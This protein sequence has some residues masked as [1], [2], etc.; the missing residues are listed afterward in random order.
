M[1]VTGTLQIVDEFN[2]PIAEAQ[3]WSF[4]SAKDSALLKKT[5]YIEDEYYSDS[6]TYSFY[7]GYTRWRNPQ[8][9]SGKC[10]LI[11]APG[12]ADIHVG[13]L[14]FNN[15]SYLPSKL[16]LK[17]YRKVAQWRGENLVTA[18]LYKTGS[19]TVTDSLMMDKS[20]YIEIL[21]EV[22]ELRPLN[23]PI[24]VFPNPANDQVEIALNQQNLSSA[25][26][27]MVDMSGA[28][29]LEADITSSSMAVNISHLKGGV[30]T[31]LFYDTGNRLIHSQ[32]LV[33]LASDY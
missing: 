18:S 5:A 13:S 20:C 21:T 29:V 23:M 19:I 10:L 12:Y 24:N 31:L 28:K 22:P 8:D 17:M 4:K 11:K 14:S 3:V 32:K 16:I 7:S 2:K 6:N 30:Y 1:W 33:K 9:K 25:W 27:I 26:C 15:S